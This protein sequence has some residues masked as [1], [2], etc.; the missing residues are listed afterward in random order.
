MK[1]YAFHLVCVSVDL[2]LI[3]FDSEENFYFDVLDEGLTDSLVEFCIAELVDVGID[4]FFCG[5][6]AFTEWVTEEKE[7][8]FALHKFHE[9]VLNSF[10][11]LFGQKL[12]VI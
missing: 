3:A 7:E 9:I 8:G 12:T 10:S 6:Y 5:L 1:T 11:E 2:K 4:I